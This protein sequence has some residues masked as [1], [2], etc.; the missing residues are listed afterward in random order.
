VAI[1]GTYE[2]FVG[3]TIGKILVGALFASALFR[4][5]AFAGAATGICL[6]Y[7]REGLTGILSFAYSVQSDFL[8]RADFTKGMVLGA[9]IAAIA[10]GLFRRRN[11]L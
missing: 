5:F 11:A 9:L 4:S 6:L 10:V 8:T 1:P 3:L 7:F 2:F